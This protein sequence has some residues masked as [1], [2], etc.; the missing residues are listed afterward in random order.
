MKK[1]IFTLFFLLAFM[2][3]GFAQDGLSYDNPESIVYDSSH[4]RYLI[5]NNGSGDLLQVS[6]SDRTAAPTLFTDAVDSPTG[7][8][9]LSNVLYVCDGNKVKG[10]QLLDASLVFELTIPEE[11]SLLND[12]TNDHQS[13]IDGPEVLYVTGTGSQMVY[14]IEIAK[15]TYEPFA[16]VTA[17]PPNGIFYDAPNH[18]LIVVF[19]AV[20]SPIVAVN[21]ADG[22]VNTITT[23]NLSLLD[24]I[25][26]DLEGNFY[27]SS[28]LSNTV[29]Q[30]AHDFSGEPEPFSLN[31]AGP[32]DLYFNEVTQTL[33]IPNFNGTAI[34]FIDFE[35]TN[36]SNLTNTPNSSLQLFPN[37]ANHSVQLNYHLVESGAVNIQLFDAV[38]R[39]IQ[40]HH[41]DHQAQGEQVYTLN[42][43]QQGL[44]DGVYFVKV[45]SNHQEAI[46]QLIINH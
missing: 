5:S 18:R 20:N 9:I 14:K 39:L 7:M 45:K 17:G 25:A 6:N 15:E 12:I 31:H 44:A 29:Y 28:F 34:D 42:W 38:G 21:L 8:L 40:E 36:V 16:A 32:A 4:E 41:M 35:V 27:I 30:F 33:A 22:S 10:F 46:N 11:N 13:Y 37:P 24:G 3:N 2:F 19:L 23:T 1:Q 26:Q 43:Q